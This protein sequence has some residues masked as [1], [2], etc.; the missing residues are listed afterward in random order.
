VKKQTIL[1]VDDEPDFLELVTFRLQR[2]GYDIITTGGGLAAL[3]KARWQNPNL[4]L[5]D[6]MLPELDGLSVCEILRRHPATADIPII[7]VTAFVSEPLQ[8]YGLKNGAKGYLTKPVNLPDLLQ[9]VRS[10]LPNGCQVT[11]NP[12]S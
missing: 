2:E 11:P 7:F 9:W 3:E 4:I 1:V 10:A 8:K 6:L 5:L 12:V